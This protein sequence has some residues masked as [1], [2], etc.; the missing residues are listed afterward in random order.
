MI[1]MMV[2]WEPE[3]GREQRALTE[4]WTGNRTEHQKEKCDDEGGMDWASGEWIGRCMAQA[5]CLNRIDPI[6]ASSNPC[7]LVHS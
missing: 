3:N 6:H 1:R 7:H 2:G 5:I 4:D